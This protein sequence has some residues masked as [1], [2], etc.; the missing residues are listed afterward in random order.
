MLDYISGIMLVF[1]KA[2]KTYL[3]CFQWHWVVLLHS[4]AH[5]GLLHKVGKG[6]LQQQKQIF[7]VVKGLHMPKQKLAAVLKGFCCMC[8][9][10]K[11]LGII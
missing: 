1:A 2:S 3:P 7:S 8:T 6:I 5:L 11:Q 10:E 9:R 4:K